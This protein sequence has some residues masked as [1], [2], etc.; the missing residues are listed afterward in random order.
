MTSMNR[1]IIA[2]NLT[3]DP[4]LRK[5]PSGTAVADISLAL[6]RRVQDRATGQ[7]HEQTT[8]VDVRLWG[9]KAE[10]THQYCAKG[11]PVLVEGRL[12]LD[13]WLDKSSGAKRSKLR[14]VAE[15]IQFLNRRP[16]TARPAYDEPGNPEEL[17][18]TSTAT[19]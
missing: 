16:S 18:L 19:L 6:N 11:Q 14:V 5:T 10:V 4:E 15:S 8:F 1:V 17:T 13:Q 3:R 12:E 2:G 9:R 7:Q